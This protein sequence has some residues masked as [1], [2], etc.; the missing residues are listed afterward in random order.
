MVQI[1]I[2]NSN[3]ITYAIKAQ[4]EKEYGKITNNNLSVW[5]SVMSEVRNAQQN[6]SQ[7]YSG[8][9]D[10]ENLNNKENWKTDFKVKKNQVFE[11][12]EN[13]WNRIVEFLTGKTPKESTTFAPKTPDT[14]VKPLEAQTVPPGPITG[15]KEGEN[16]EYDAIVRGGVR[17]SIQ[18]AVPEDTIVKP[19]EAQIVPPGPITGPNEGENPEY[20]AIVKG[21]QV[22]DG[23]VVEL[24]SPVKDAHIINSDPVYY[25]DGKSSVD[26]QNYREIK[27]LGV[28]IKYD[29]QPGKDGKGFNFKSEGSV[30]FRNSEVYKFFSG[31]SSVTSDDKHKIQRDN[32]GNY[33]YRGMKA[34]SQNML[35][36]KINSVSSRIS[37]NHA[38]YKDLAAR[39][40]AGEELTQAEQDFMKSHLKSIDRYMLGVDENGNLIDKLE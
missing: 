28:S 17:P 23:Q 1:N 14:T 7:I 5:Q 4:V 22:S 26:T 36:Q 20:D 29:I 13:V 27:A 31:A 32:D 21:A 15:P 24:H 25:D 37:V 40:N 35:Q 11:L 19:L 34:K 12:A 33:T 16:P 2:G 18:E 39:K 10:I 9:S 6:G 38:V 8:G 30:S 3:G